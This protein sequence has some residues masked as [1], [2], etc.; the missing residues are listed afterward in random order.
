MLEKYKIAKEVCNKALNIIDSRVGESF[1][2]I[3]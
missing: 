2:Q 3:I 1:T